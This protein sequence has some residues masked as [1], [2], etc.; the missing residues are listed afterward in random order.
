MSAPGDAP[1]ASP[2]GPVRWWFE[3]RTTGKIVIA[4]LPNLPLWIFL[5]ALAVQLL[6]HPTGRLGLAVEIVAAIGLTWWALD[7][8][9]RGVNP[10][11]RFLGA[12][13]IVAEVI[14]LV[15]TVRG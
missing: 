1:P 11:R 7:E 3:D 5:A 10:W 14:D 12:A 13:A 6:L 2:R 15:R 9:I 8:I 4:Q